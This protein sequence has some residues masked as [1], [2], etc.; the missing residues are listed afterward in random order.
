MASFAEKRAEVFEE[1]RRLVPSLELADEH[2]C[3]SWT[4]TGHQSAARRPLHVVTVRKKGES[5]ALMSFLMEAR[6]FFL[7]VLNPVNPT[8]IAGCPLS[9]WLPPGGR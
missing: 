9:G 3:C 8:V 5:F 6:L 2:W 7:F 4:V 1:A